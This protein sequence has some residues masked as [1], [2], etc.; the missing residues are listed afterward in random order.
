MI[1]NSLR[2]LLFA[3]FSL[4]SIASHPVEAQW[5]SDSVTNTVVCDTTGQQD[6]P[7][8]CSDGSN[9]AIIVWE[10]IRI[11]NYTIYAQHLNANGN[12]T[13][14]RNGIK[15]ATSNSD[16]RYPIIASDGNGGAYVVWQDS[17]NSSNDG[18]DLYGQHILANG[19]VGYAVG[20]VA[21]ANAFGNQDNAVI[22]SD[23][24]GN[25]FV[26]WEDSRASNSSNR[27]DIY[28]NRMTSGGVSFGPSG[29]VVD[30]S[31]N[32]QVGPSI[33]ADGTGGCYVAWEDEGRVPSPI[34]ARRISSSGTMLWGQPPPSPGVLIYQAPATANNPQPNSSNVSI[35]LDGNQ[36]LLTWEVT[37]ATSTANAQDILAQRMHCSTTSDTSKE[38]GDFPIQVTGDWLNDQTSPKIFSDDSLIGSGSESVHG[39]LVPFLDL[40]P[41]STDDVDVAMV[42]VLGDGLT[43]MPPAGNGFFFLEQQPL[44]QTGFKAVKITDSDPTKDGIIAVWDDARYASL[45]LGKDTTIF[46]QRIDRNGRKYF[47]IGG[48]TR[49]ALPLCSGPNSGGWITKQVA[50]APRTDGG[51]AVWTDYRK[52]NTNPN[53]YAQLILMTGAISIPSDTTPPTLVIQS[54]TPPNID[55]A[56]QAQCTNVLAFDAGSLKSGIESVSAMSMSNMQLQTSSFAIGADSVTFSV[57]VMDTFQNG[58]GTVKVEDTS[59]NVRNM[60]FTYCTIPDIHAPRITWDSLTSHWLIL[61]V[62]DDSSWDRGLKS[63]MVTGTS[64]VS[65]SNSGANIVSG[66]LTFDDTISITDS[67]FPSGFCIKAVDVAN[68]ASANDC[69]TYTPAG[70]AVTTP[71][72]NPIS[73]SIYP[74]PTSSDVTIRLEGTPVADITILDVL[75]RTIDRF[76][77]ESSQSWQAGSLAPGT[78]IVRAAI[79]DLVVCKRMVRE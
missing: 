47:P 49:L 18:I 1:R 54:T 30:A 67:T 14:T 20:G 10:D 60:S 58:S 28:L 65:L 43:T 36:L 78:Y 40:Q 22:C 33:C 79:G 62:R 64:N 25:A 4:I 61:H 21:V 46:V 70:D 42:R 41:G 31:I 72:A 55:S 56:C 24:N 74:N 19:T 39:F 11:G 76:R 7:Q 52:G 38:F 73:L 13:W 29:M 3:S 51:I 75:G 63:V 45:G 9:G 23:G 44:A 2:S 12:A 8:I 59:L 16:Q 53:I 6:A 57:C 15:L 26:A 69:F 50:L 66:Q 48:N 34:Y 35:S 68:N 27:P 77:I 71:A 17:R 32:H 5:A 37:S